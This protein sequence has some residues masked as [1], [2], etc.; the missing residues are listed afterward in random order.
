MHASSGQL[1]Y[2]PN[3]TAKILVD[4]EI[5]NY[6][7][8][9]IP[10]HYK[11]QKQKYAPHITVVRTKLETPELTH[12]NKYAL[13][14]IHFQ[15]DGCVLFDGEYFYLDVVCERIG[16][17]RREL[18]LPTYRQDNKGYHIT[19]GNCKSGDTFTWRW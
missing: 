5:V 9:L 15:Y 7:R 6:Y 1:I 16:E 19:L 11:V 2:E 14:E 18:G 12:W 17:I 13:E 3:L 4:A 8:A 10:S